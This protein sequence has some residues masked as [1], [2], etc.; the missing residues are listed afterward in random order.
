[1][2]IKIFL[3]NVI[4]SKASDLHLVAGLPPTLRIN[5]ELV[6]IPS[7]GVLTPDQIAELLKGVLASEQIERLSVNKEIDFSLNFS[8]NDAGL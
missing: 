2:D 3:Q 6:P 8:E 4:D 7:A 5:G 1:M